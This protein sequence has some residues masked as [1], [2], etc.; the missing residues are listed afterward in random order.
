MKR[1]VCKLFILGQSEAVWCLLYCGFAIP[2]PSHAS[3][4]LCAVLESDADLQPYNKTYMWMHPAD[5]LL[6]VAA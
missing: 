6:E 2:F 5:F 4:V 1:R 3:A